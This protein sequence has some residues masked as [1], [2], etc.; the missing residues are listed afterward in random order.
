[1][2]SFED[3]QR[4]GLRRSPEDLSEIQSEDEVIA[5]PGSDSD[6]HSA[7]TDTDKPSEGVDLPESPEAEAGMN[8]SGMP[9]LSS[10]NHEDDNPFEYDL[11]SNQGPMENDSENA[12]EAWLSKNVMPSGETETAHHDEHS[13]KQASFAREQDDLNA[14]KRVVFTSIEPPTKPLRQV[15]E[16][17][18]KLSGEEQTYTLRTMDKFPSLPAE[19][20]KRLAKAN[21]VR[22]HRLA[23]LQPEP[24]DWEWSTF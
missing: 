4:F 8:H 5:G 12:V 11:G 7:S 20:A 23:G 9:R 10:P 1:M 2:Q 14:L 16:G 13:K 3:L 21:A 19:I 15:V 18:D 17:F 24:R 6:S 22:R